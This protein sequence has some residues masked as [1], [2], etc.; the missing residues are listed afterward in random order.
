MDLVNTFICN[1]DVFKSCSFL[2][3]VQWMSM[4]V[5]KQTNE[6]NAR[7]SNHFFDSYYRSY[8][9]YVS[10]QQTSLDL[11]FYNPKNATV[12]MLLLCYLY[13]TL[14][15]Y[16]NYGLE[17]QE[18]TH[19]DLRKPKNLLNMR[20]QLLNFGFTYCYIEIATRMCHFMPLV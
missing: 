19:L 6:K 1:I 12:K 15:L 9:K 17:R 2:I 5:C 10:D 4:K 16:L 3:V 14:Y 20:C 13:S 18:M 8:K 11:L 7:F